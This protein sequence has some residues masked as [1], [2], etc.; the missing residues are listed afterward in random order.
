MLKLSIENLTRMTDHI[1]KMKFVDNPQI[2]KTLLK[3]ILEPLK[4]SVRAFL[5]AINFN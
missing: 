1:S 4:F 2:L 3:A 5:H